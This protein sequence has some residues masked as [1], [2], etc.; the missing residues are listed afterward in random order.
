METLHFSH[1]EGRIKER[2][3][4]ENT[5][6]W[7]FL[8]TA[9]LK[10]SFWKVPEMASF[11]FLT[12]QHWFSAAMPVSTANCVKSESGQRK[13]GIAMKVELF[14]IDCETS[15]NR[16]SL[17]LPAVIGR[18]NDADLVVAH[19]EVS[20]KH[21]RLFS[22]QNSLHVQDLNSLN[23]TTVAG[24]KIQNAQ[25]AILPDEIFSVGPVQF[26]VKYQRSEVPNSEISG[27]TSRK[28][29]NSFAA[30]PVSANS[31]SYPSS[32]KLRKTV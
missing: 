6:K 26:R 9:F 19:P 5:L 8:E 24:R 1:I 30:S 27:S 31:Q 15:S 23:G 11:G 29:R 22:F 16:I 32:L 18:G 12:N 14:V 21:C 25:S 13:K 17:T 2:D 28:S 20:R 7:D 3:S 10:L 4:G